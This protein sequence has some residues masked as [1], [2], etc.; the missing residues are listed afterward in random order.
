[1]LKRIRQ[2]IYN[3]FGSKRGLLNAFK[4]GFC[5]RLGYYKQYQRIDFKRVNRLV[6]ICSGNICR[7]AFADYY[8]RSMGLSSVSY[9]LH[10]RGGDPADPRAI[11]FAKRQG[12][13][14][15]GHITQNIKQY[16]PDAGDLVIGMEPSH[17]FE[18]KPYINI[19]QATI[20]PLWHDKPSAYLHDPFSSNPVFFDKC[21]ESLVNIVDRISQSIK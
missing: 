8:A 19:Q 6:F 5:H 11:D 12:I 20:A 14:M 3:D 1:M 13:D 7:S 9:G 18:L 16:Q 2:K 15:T 10:C 17:M 4:Y 21:E